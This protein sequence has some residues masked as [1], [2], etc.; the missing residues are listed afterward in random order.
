M[1]LSN[2]FLFTSTF[3]YVSINQI[4]QCLFFLLFISIFNISWLYHANLNMCLTCS[5]QFFQ[6]QFQITLHV[7]MFE[8][9]N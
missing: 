8:E 3:I 6:T 4:T 2:K 7:S 1:M 9:M 5:Y